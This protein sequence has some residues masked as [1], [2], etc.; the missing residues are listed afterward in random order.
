MNL[1]FRF[2][3]ASDLHIALP[4]TIWDHPSRFHL[5]EVGIPALEVVLQDLETLELDFLLIPGDLTQHGEP[6]NHTWLANRLA[7][8]PFPTYV[9]PGNHDVPNLLANEQSIGL[10]DFPAYYQNFGYQNPE[11]LYYTCEIFPGVQLIGLNSNFFDDSGQQVG[12]IDSE[13][14]TWLESVLASKNT[15]LAIVMLHHNLLEHLPN[16]SHHGLGKRYMLENALQLRQ[17]LEKYGVQLVFTGHLH[18][19]DV[20]YENGLYDITT[21][22]LVSYPHPYRILEVRTDCQGVTWLEIISKRVETVPDFPDLA[23]MSRNWIGDRSLP[24]TLKLL[25]ETSLSLSSQRTRQTALELKYFWADVAR[26]DADFQFPNLPVE[27]RKYFEDFG[28]IAPDGNLAFIDNHSTF[29]LS[30]NY[31]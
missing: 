14:L 7:K 6:K 29:L 31:V 11:K 20:A 5:V 12:R 13:Q 23:N 18:V 3:I 27:V 8:L 10:T 4:E 30:P 17:M 16:Q 24:F 22:S 1:N 28:A 2:A 9:I 19:Q 21:G 15:D 25:S 26:G